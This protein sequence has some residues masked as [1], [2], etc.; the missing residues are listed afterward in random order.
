MHRQ[1]VCGRYPL[2]LEIRV[3]CVLR[4]APTY[5]RTFRF[6]RKRNGTYRGRS[7]V[8][9]DFAKDPAKTHFIQQKE[10]SDTHHLLQPPPKRTPLEHRLISVH[11]IELGDQTWRRKWSPLQ[12]SLCETG[13]V[14]IRRTNIRIQHIFSRI[15]IERSLTLHKSRNWDA[16]VCSILQRNTVRHEN[17]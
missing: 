4:R 1:Q 12:I 13:R 15:K 7:S 6:C 3:V 11:R 17:T 14:E 2:K 10:A 5:S 9:T 16:I 8:S